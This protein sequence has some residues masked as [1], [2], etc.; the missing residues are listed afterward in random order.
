MINDEDGDSMSATDIFDWSISSMVPGKR[1]NQHDG[2]IS[3]PQ[4]TEG[5]MDQLQLGG[6]LKNNSV[7]D[8]MLDNEAPASPPCPHRPE[9]DQQPPS[10]TSDTLSK[11]ID[12]AGE[13][14]SKTSATRVTSPVLQNISVISDQQRTTDQVGVN[15]DKVKAIPLL[16]DSTVFEPQIPKFNM[17]FEQDQE[18]KAPDVSGQLSSRFTAMKEAPKLKFSLNNMEATG[19][20]PP[21]APSICKSRIYLSKNQ[22][23]IKSRMRRSPVEIDSCIGRTQSVL[24][25][26]AQISQLVKS[27]KTSGECSVV[28]IEDVPS[29]SD[30]ST[31]Q[32]TTGSMGSQSSSDK[33][34]SSISLLSG[35]PTVMYI[36]KVPR[37]VSPVMTVVEDEDE[38]RLLTHLFGNPAVSHIDVY[39]VSRV[40][41]CV[42]AGDDVGPT[43]R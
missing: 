17:A 16:P 7:S 13:S 32:N 22:P 41:P 43:A 30:V 12:L 40:R 26:D 21:S 8:T 14:L 9:Y 25:S 4:N 36:P 19:Y 37:S 34:S 10:Q 28:I 39:P 2:C 3:T 6:S 5:T 23:Q 31:T 1:H 24:F 27:Y 18:S 11:A 42:P 35:L 33:S 20:V 15:P 29:T 38:M